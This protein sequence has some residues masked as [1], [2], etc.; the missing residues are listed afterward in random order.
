[1]NTVM[2]DLALGLVLMYSVLSLFVTVLQ[3]MLVNSVFRWRSV[4]LGTSVQSAFGEDPKLTQ[5]FF[6]HPLIVSLSKGTGGRKPSYIPPEMFAKAFLAVLGRGQHPAE[7]GLTP[8]SFLASLQAGGAGT[9]SSTSAGKLDFVAALTAATQGSGDD[10]ATFEKQIETW[11]D[12]IGERARGWYKRSSQYWALGLSLLLAV[13]LNVDSVMIARTLWTDGQLRT[14][15]AVLATQVNAVQQA[16]TSG[17]AA[18]TPVLQNPPTA[19]ERL[20]KIDDKLEDLVLR[21]GQDDYVKNDDLA[22][23]S[24]AKAEDDTKNATKTLPALIGKRCDTKE[25]FVLGKPA[26]ARYPALEW[27]ENFTVLRVDLAKEL[28]ED[29]E[30]RKEKLKTIRATLRA[31]SEEMLSAQN[32]LTARSS[33]LLVADLNRR[34]LGVEREITDALSALARTADTQQRSKVECSLAFAGDKTAQDLCG[35][36]LSKIASLGLPMGYDMSVVVRQAS[37]EDLQAL[38]KKGCDQPDG[39]PKKAEGCQWSFLEAM[40]VAL[41]GGAWVGWLLTAIALSLGAPFWFDLLNRLVK[42]RASIP[43]ETAEA[44]ETAKKGDDAAT[45]T[46]KVGQTAPT[47]GTSD[48]ATEFEKQL[49]EDE[50]RALQ[51]KLLQAPTGVFDAET[52]AAIAARRGQLGM[53]KGST[54]DATLYEAIMERRAP[55]LKPRPI[56]RPGVT[57]PLLVPELRTRLSA[58]LGIP[59]RAQGSGDQFDSEVRAAVRLFQGRANLEPDGEMGPQS[60]S[61]LD[62]GGGS[63]P[64]ADTWMRIAIDKLGLDETVPAHVP[65]IVEFLKQVPATAAA[66]DPTKTAWCACFVAYIIGKALPNS[67]MPTNNPAL[68]ANWG[69]WGTPVLKGSPEYGAITVLHDEHNQQHHVGFMVGRTPSGTVLLGGNQGQGGKVSVLL[70]DDDHYKVT[71]TGMPS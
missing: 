43:P 70:F 59:L 46:D 42:L 63:A 37:R 50:R 33:A 48:V 16:S 69:N 56:L 44:K 39:S 58:L 61:I 15:L 17:A 67:A 20:R 7:N 65:E 52:R 47:T 41:R 34:V 38:T 54:I 31:I 2:I 30:K 57:D 24:C 60:W 55:S 35:E 23:M 13:L 11:F 4:H 53:T 25:L 66:T 5:A 9:V 8:S 29:T 32:A 12:D 49:S 22:R 10:W 36:R 62:A 28:Y 21:T 18:P 26:K 27:S 64:A 71:Y 45:T 68:A 40:R 6:D 51:R 1:M 14:Q 19:E 3:E